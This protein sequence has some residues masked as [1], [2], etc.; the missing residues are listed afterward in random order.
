[1]TALEEIKQGRYGLTDARE[2]FDDAVN[3][4][5]LDQ[6]RAGIDIVSDGEMRRWYFVQSFYERMEGLERQPELR[7]VGVYGDDMPP[8]YRPLGVSP[9]HRGWALR[10]SFAMP[11]RSPVNP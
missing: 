2:A 11:V 8:R 4:A 10:T 7:K 9:C 5:I 1:M 3:T 6:E